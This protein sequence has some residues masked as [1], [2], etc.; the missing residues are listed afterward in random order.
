VDTRVP[1]LREVPEDVRDRLERLAAHEG[2]W[3]P[4]SA[5]ADVLADLPDHAVAAYEVVGVL[6]EGRDRR[7]LGR[8]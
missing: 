6:E 8:P 5:D 3:V 4:A 7:R 1:W 2:S